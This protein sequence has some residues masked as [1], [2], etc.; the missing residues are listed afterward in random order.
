MRLSID[1]LVQAHTAKHR[2]SC[3]GL[4]EKVEVPNHVVVNEYSI[5]T[6][7]A[8]SVSDSP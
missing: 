8:K 4:K 1:P 5:G 6:D 3:T 7:C 2:S